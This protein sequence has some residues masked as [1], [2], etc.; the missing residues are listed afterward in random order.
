MSVLPKSIPSGSREKISVE[1]D[2]KNKIENAKILVV[3][4]AEFSRCLIQEIFSANGFKNIT[5]VEDGE[6]AI[7]ATK[8][9]EPDLVLL[10]LMMP[11]L[12]GF[13][14]CKEV[15]KDPRFSDTPILVQSAT[16]SPERITKAFKVGATDFVSK[17]INADEMIA[18]SKVHLQNQFLLHDLKMYQSRVKQELND[19]KQMQ[20]STMPSDIDIKDIE[21]KYNLNIA[22]HFETSSEL[23]GDFWG[24]IP[25]SKNA[26]GIYSV[27]FSGHGV[28]AALNT[29]RLHTIL[30]EDNKIKSPAE[31]LFELNNKL[32]P[33]LSSGQFATMFFGI[34]DMD[35]NEIE[36]S[37]AGAPA[38]FLIKENGDVDI[39]NAVGVPLGVIKSV[40]YDNQKA[41][42]NSG[43]TIVLYSDALIETED[44]DGGFISE[45]EIKSIF[46]ASASV[47]ARKKLA[48]LMQKFR[49][50]SSNPIRDDLTINIFQ[51]N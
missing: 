9:L 39:L 43:E 26:L 33:L 47:S 50:H 31:F 18:R 2:N 1:E 34:I 28:M 16:T 42:L 7:E 41:D 30:K 5:L 32:V 6:E 51:R 8:E 22:E 3:D 14:Y 27:D 48:A 49:A 12:D 35:K 4:D 11:K 38:P 10:D 20:K 44:D 40:D 45:D 19:A 25:I 21:K 46:K 24:M 29:F 23:G 13:E 36:Y 37:S 17:P 15:R